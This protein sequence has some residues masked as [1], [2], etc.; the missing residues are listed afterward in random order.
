MNRVQSA[1]IED[2]ELDHFRKLS[3]PM[4]REKLLDLIFADETEQLRIRLPGAKRFDG[5]DGI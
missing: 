5:I 2:R 1:A 4:P 3:E